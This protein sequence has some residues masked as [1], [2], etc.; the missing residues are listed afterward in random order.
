MLKMPKALISL[1]LFCSY[2]WAQLPAN[3]VLNPI[4]S[5]IG[6]PLAVRHAGDGS[7]RLFIMDQSG[8]IRIWDGSQ[9]LNQPFL[10]ISAKVIFSGERG[11]LGIDFDPLYAENG[12]FYVSYS[13][14]AAPQGD[15]IIERYQVSSDN[16]NQ[17]NA[18]SGVILMRVEQPYANHNGGDIHFGPDGYLYFGLGDGG[19][20]GDPQNYAQNTAQLLGKMLRIDVNPDIVFKNSLELDNTCGLDAKNYYVPTDNPFA[21]NSS[22]C[23]EIWAYGFRNPWRW[24]FDRQTGDLLISDVGQNEVEEIN[25][26]AAASKGGENYGW[27]CREGNDDYNLSLCADGASYVEPVITHTHSTEN[28]CSITG[29]YVYRGPIT[30]L[31]GLYVYSDWCRGDV[32]FATSGSPTWSSQT[33]Q[34]VGFGTTSFGEDEQGNIYMTQG[35]NVY[36]FD[37]Q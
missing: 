16:P 15:S 21:Q 2:A 22:A 13:Q 7:G 23:G 11:L 9:V 5:N 19:S 27:R 28:Y 35:S 20:Q 31:Q 8:V 1:L 10:D 25:F 3:L 37:L 33:F 36:R 34:N 4:I 6:N 17:A 14:Q 30:A 24:S 26:Q 18:Q 32:N 12:Y 29:G